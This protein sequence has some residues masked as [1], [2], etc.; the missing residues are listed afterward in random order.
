MMELFA[1]AKINLSLE[2]K[3]RR[4]DGLHEIE[5]LVV[6]VS[7]FDRLEIAH[8]P[9]E[10][11]HFSSDA[12]DLPLDER[13]LVVKAARLFCATCGVQ[14][15][16]LIHL[17]KRIPHGAGLGGGSS[18]AATTLLGLNR[19]F[20]TELPLEALVEMAAELGS[21][22]PAF[23]LQ[24][25]VMM[26]GRGERVEAATFRETVPLLL[27]KP[28]FAVPTPWAYSRWREAREIPGVSYAPQE[29]G[30]ATLRNDLERPVFEKYI[31]L[32]TLKE[33]L[34]AQEGEVLGALMS[35]SGSTV[36]AVLRS[37]EAAFPLGERLVGE[38]GQDLWL[39][40]CETI[41]P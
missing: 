30:F 20:E 4:D 37:P 31:F 26:R 8:G 22:V 40:A 12:A 15:R 23:L 2:V 41:A 21:D 24:R 10:E 18:D 27:V 25:P 5:S 7:V 19:L 34:R 17:E 38:F 9:D 32:A 29:L 6:P 16:L 3:G 28:P 39:H 1:P 11:L 36:F 14:P 33:W 13:N 35:G